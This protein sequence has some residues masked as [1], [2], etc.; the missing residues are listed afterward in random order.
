ML[1]IC[2]RSAICFGTLLLSATPV[3]PQI[4][5]LQAETPREHPK[6]TEAPI[7]DEICFTGLR[8]IGAAAVAAQIAAHPGDRFDPAKIEGDVRRLARLGW[9]ESIQ[10]EE[11]PSV[12]LLAQ[13]PE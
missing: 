2:L 10:V 6:T 12:A 8:R 13:L 4:H 7:L 9:F 1:V 5:G 11:A 3:L